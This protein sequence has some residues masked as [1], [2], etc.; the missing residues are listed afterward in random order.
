M[1]I[2]T[3][4]LFQVQDIYHAWYYQWKTP[5]VN[6]RINFEKDILFAF[7]EKIVLC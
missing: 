2:Y 5:F 3:G 1:M 4:I 6:I 7:F